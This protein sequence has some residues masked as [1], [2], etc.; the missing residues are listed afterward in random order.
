MYTPEQI[1]EVM[2]KDRDGIL[3]MLED[4]G[5]IT[6][7]PPERRGTYL[8]GTAAN[9]RAICLAWGNGQEGRVTLEILENAYEEI[10]A[11]GL[12]FPFLFFGRTCLV[13]SPDLFEFMQIP[14]VFELG[15][16]WPTLRAFNLRG[17]PRLAQRTVERG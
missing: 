16:I 7:L 3:A 17:K 8:V 1:H 2:N 10:A 5:Y 14:I 13:V 15:E 9:N 12:G 4:S 6:L 11:A